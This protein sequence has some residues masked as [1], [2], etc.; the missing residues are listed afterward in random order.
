MPTPADRPTPSG[1][2]PGGVEELLDVARVVTLPMR[3][4]FRGITQREA[5]LLPGP[6]GLGRVLPLPR[7]R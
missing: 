7:V 4:K 5:L 6:A 3:V 2:N 1:Q